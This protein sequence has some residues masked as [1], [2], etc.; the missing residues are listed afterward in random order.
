MAESQQEISFKA[1]AVITQG[2]ALQDLAVVCCA[3]VSAQ[4]E[5][6][7]NTVIVGKQI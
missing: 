2:V 4:E 6:F 7:R 3:C 1:S 5:Q